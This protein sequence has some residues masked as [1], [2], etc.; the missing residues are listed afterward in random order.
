MQPHQ[1]LAIITQ[2]STTYFSNSVRLVFASV[3]YFIHLRKKRS[4]PGKMKQ[5]RGK[6]MEKMKTQLQIWIKLKRKHMQVSEQLMKESLI[7]H[8]RNFTCKESHIPVE[9]TL[10]KCNKGIQFN[11]KFQNINFDLICD[12]S[13]WTMERRKGTNTLTRRNQFMV[14]PISW[15]IQS[16]LVNSIDWEI[17]SL[18]AI[19]SHHQLHNQ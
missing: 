10:A 1:L 12:H 8:F 16:L 6:K 2:L 11:S 18:T 14:T 19:W 9:R 5:R 7:L 3:K 13:G 17:L 15:S 4:Y